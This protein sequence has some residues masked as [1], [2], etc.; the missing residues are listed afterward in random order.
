[1]ANERLKILS[2]KALNTPEL[3]GVYIMRDAKKQIIYI[4]KAKILKNRV[5]QYF[6][7]GERHEPKVQKMVDNVFD[8][9][10]VVCTSE[11]EALILECSLIKQNQ[12]KYNILLKDD[13]G[14]HYI[15]ITTGSWPRIT[16]EKQKTDDNAQYLGPYN[17]GFAGQQ[18]SVCGIKIV[19]I[20]SDLY[21]TSL[22][23]AL[24]IEIIRI[25]ADLLLSGNS[26][27][28]FEVI[29]TGGIFLPSIL[30]SCLYGCSSP[31]RQAGYGSCGRR[32][33]HKTGSQAEGRNHFFDCHGS[34][35]L[36]LVSSIIHLARKFYD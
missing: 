23:I 33:D 34:S 29:H 13:K 2:E 18:P 32:G 10:Y 22:T 21:D 28:V 1:M 19:G 7:E 30:D 11:F 4:G 17:S 27:A 12:P 8:F 14:Y 6:R 31:L 35:P 36:L 15:K 20:F 16:A 3:P 25:S 24:R 9:D 5:S 26:P